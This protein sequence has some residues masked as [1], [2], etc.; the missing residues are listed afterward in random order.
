MKMKLGW[1]RDRMGKIREVSICAPN[2]NHKWRSADGFSS[3]DDNGKSFVGPGCDLIEFLLPLEDLPPSL[4]SA[5]KAAEI[6]H[7]ELRAHAKAL[8]ALAED[9]TRLA[10]E[11][12][13]QLER[14]EKE[15]E[16][17]K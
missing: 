2:H 17:G 1:W 8:Q 15:C 4:N 3:W 11:A 12:L 14:L 16:V 13:V 6:H 5:V 9:A 7:K 10:D